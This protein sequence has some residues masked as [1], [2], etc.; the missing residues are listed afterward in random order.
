MLLGVLPSSLAE[1][2]AKLGVRRDLQKELSVPSRM[3]QL[4]RFWPAQRKSAQDKRACVE[5]EFLFAKVALLAGKVD[6]FELAEPQFR[7][8]DDG[9]TGANCGRNGRQ[10]SV[11]VRVS[12]DPA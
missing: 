1:G 7:H 10:K 5:R 2:Q 11:S 4:T 12:V 3:G 9:K 6:R 8:T